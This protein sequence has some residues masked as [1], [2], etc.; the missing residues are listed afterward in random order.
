M[1]TPIN[2]ELRELRM[3][4]EHYVN[5]L[6]HDVELKDNGN[7]EGHPLLNKDDI[8]KINSKIDGLSDRIEELLIIEKDYKEVI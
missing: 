3:T 5:I 7:P 8:K 6:K 2:K 4:K 1:S